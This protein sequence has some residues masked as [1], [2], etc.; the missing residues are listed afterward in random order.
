MLFLLRINL[1][2]KPEQSKR[3]TFLLGTQTGA[4]DMGRFDRPP[5]AP[6]TPVIA[7]LIVLSRIPASTVTRVSGGVRARSTTDLGLRDVS[8]ISLL[9]TSPLSLIATRTS[10]DRLKVPGSK[11][12]PERID[13]TIRF[14]LSFACSLVQRIRVRPVQI[15]FRSS[16]PVWSSL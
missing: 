8:Q 6:A 15:L 9:S 5:N 7:E 2:I 16:F 10:L 3:H 11:I 1:L 4:L 13:V 12:L 14:R